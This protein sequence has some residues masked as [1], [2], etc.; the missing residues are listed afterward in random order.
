[1]VLFTNINKAFSGGRFSF[2]RITCINCPKV[3]SFG[4]KYLVLSRGGSSLS[5]VSTIM[6]ILSGY[7]SKIRFDS[8]RRCF[9]E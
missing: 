6:G 8:S 7:L 4:V 9:R 3:R 1:M 2:P 5:F